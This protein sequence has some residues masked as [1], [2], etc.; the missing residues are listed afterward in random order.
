[1]K[2]VFIAAAMTAALFTGTTAN[3]LA[4][5]RAAVPVGTV[6][7]CFLTIDAA[8]VSVNGEDH[9]VQA[10]E[11]V[12][13]GS[14]SFK[15]VANTPTGGTEFE[16]VSLSFTGNDPEYGDFTFNFDAW[17]PPQRTTLEP[18]QADAAFP[19]T[20]HVYANVT[21][22]VSGFPDLLF[23]NINECHFVSRNLT[24]FNP[25]VNETYQLGEDVTFENVAP[26]GYTTRITIKAGATVVM[27]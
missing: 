21:G 18:N 4:Q 14:A 7:V 6:I 20:A 3:I 15:S 2:K 23:T 8:T 10:A 17:R 16:P 27:N 25:Q 13:N 11:G 12:D 9:A 1:M 5:S 24:S 19:A 22:T 26:D